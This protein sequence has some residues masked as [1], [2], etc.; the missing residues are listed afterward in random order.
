MTADA[1]LA[2]YPAC[3]LAVAWTETIICGKEEGRLESCWE[4]MMGV[5]P[6]LSPAKVLELIRMALTEEVAE[7]YGSSNKTREALAQMDHPSYL[8]YLKGK[9]GAV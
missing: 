9:M 4:L 5:M 3:P 1:L 6:P 2:A 7:G 8:T